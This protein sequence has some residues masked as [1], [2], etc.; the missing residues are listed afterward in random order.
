MS[1]RD[2]CQ[3]SMFTPYM[4]G[5]IVLIGDKT[6]IVKSMMSGWALTS[7]G[8]YKGIHPFIQNVKAMADLIHFVE[9]EFIR[10]KHRKAAHA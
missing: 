9:T 5:D 7:T 10:A 8:D 4:D 6:W 1:Q 2:P 3:V